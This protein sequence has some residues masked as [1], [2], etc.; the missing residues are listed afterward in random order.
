MVPRLGENEEWWSGA[1]GVNEMVHMLCESMH[2][3]YLDVWEDFVDSSK[4]YK[5]DGVHL[6]LQGE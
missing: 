4:L 6:I 3:S 5:K 1:L 2:C